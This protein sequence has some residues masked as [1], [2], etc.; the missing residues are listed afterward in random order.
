MLQALPGCF[1]RAAV[2]SLDSGLEGGLEGFGQA[3]LLEIQHGASMVQRPRSQ[4]VA[5]PVPSNQSSRVQST[6]TR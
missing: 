2:A 4:L 5:A 6:V 1:R 3:L